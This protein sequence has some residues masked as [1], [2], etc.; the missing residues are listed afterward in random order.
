MSNWSKTRRYAD[1]PQQPED[2]AA[3]RTTEPQE[4]FYAD[5]RDAIREGDK[6]RRDAALA[7]EQAMVHTTNADKLVRFLPPSLGTFD[8]TKEVVTAVNRIEGHDGA[9]MF[10]D[11]RIE[12]R[13]PNA[14][15]GSKKH[16]LIYRGVRDGVESIH[17]RWR[18][19]AREGLLI[20]GNYHG[21]KHAFDLSAA[22]RR[23]IV[24]YFCEGQKTA[25]AIRKRLSSEYATRRRIEVGN[26]IFV[27]CPVFGGKSG[28][29]NINWQFGL[30]PSH[31]YSVPGHNDFLVRYQ[32]IAV[33]CW[34]L[35]NDTDGWEEAHGA[36]RGIRK[37]HP[38][39]KFHLIHPPAKSPYGWD[40][41]DALPEGTSEQQRIEQLLSPERDDTTDYTVDAR[42]GA[43]DPSAANVA[44]WLG[45]KS[46]LVFLDEFRGEIFVEQELP[47]IER[48]TPLPR[49]LSDEDIIAV[50]LHLQSLATTDPRFVKW[51]SLTKV[52]IRDALTKLAAFNR[53]NTMRDKYLDAAAQWDG[54][55]RVDTFFE[56]YFLVKDPRMAREASRI[57]LLQLAA[58][59]IRPGAK[60]DVIPLL[61]GPQGSYK[62][63]T[64]AAL[65]DDGEFSDTLPDLS[66]PV[67]AAK[68]CIGKLC[69]E[70]SELSAMR[71]SEVEHI[72]SFV[73]RTEDNVRLAYDKFTKT[74]PRTSCFVGTTNDEECLA[75]YTGNRRFICVEIDG[76]R[77]MPN[78]RS[79][80]EHVRELRR[81]IIGE[82]IHRVQEGEKH[83]TDDRE[84]SAYVLSRNEDYR[85]EA[86]FETLLDDLF[87][88]YLTDANV[89]LP[90]KMLD[91][92]R[93]NVPGLLTVKK[94]SI[95]R[96][97]KLRGW[98]SDLRRG[99]LTKDA[100]MV[101]ARGEKREPSKSEIA[102]L[103]EKR[104]SW[105][106]AATNTV[107]HWLHW[108]E[109][110]GG[111]GVIT[112]RDTISMYGLEV[113]LKQSAL[114]PRAED[115]K[116]DD[117]DE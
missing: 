27:V 2:D 26:P 85:R 90:A 79:P 58:R 29:T 17:D 44:T 109:R 5:V 65:F 28:I 59:I 92:I 48:P 11:V 103:R 62:S 105:A 53:R 115:F 107:T 93:A 49:A 57:F 54:V 110:P 78:G 32:D 82:A 91:R 40:D 14:E 41:A 88:P 22:T 106:Q 70:M 96:W 45:K 100:Q 39:G 108:E 112:V 13:S 117:G 104:Q 4:F 99:R 97:F 34:V 102:E 6:A 98:T 18:V 36:A 1:R 73:S 61:I 51:P 64:L 23:P 37:L 50:T 46:N 33:T 25:T 113:L 56:D 8:A 20:P 42:T 24:L 101:D 89:A 94:S 16:L 63:S 3:H 68:Y 60:C 35:D 19:L 81:L 55:P 43:F 9:A 87:G 7:E 31:P 71:R 83:W 114:T 30:D 77:E 21:L 52:H 80:P 47:G 74:F 75:D 66:N 72:K 116:C 69:I 84:L 12:P 111:R 67:E 95:A 38:K 76:P 15:P 10:L 86:P